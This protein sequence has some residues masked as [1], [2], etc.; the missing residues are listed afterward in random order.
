MYKSCI[1]RE[2]PDYWT[3]FMESIEI[4]KGLVND[5]CIYSFGCWVCLVYCWRIWLCIDNWK[6]PVC[7]NKRASYDGNYTSDLGCGLAG[8]T[9]CCKTFFSKVFAGALYCVYHQLYI[10]TWNWEKRN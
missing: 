8:G 5:E 9:F 4:D 1:S 6:H 7:K 10:D 3:C 2:R